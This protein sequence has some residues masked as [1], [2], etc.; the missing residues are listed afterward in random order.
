MRR[1]MEGFQS[2][3]NTVGDKLNEDGGGGFCG[4]DKRAFVKVEEG[5]GQYS[6]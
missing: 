3:C 4:L 2:I 1:W 6:E 5:A